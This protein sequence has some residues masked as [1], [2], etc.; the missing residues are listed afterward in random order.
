MEYILFP[1]E[2]HGF[3]KVPNR[4]RSDVEVTRWFVRVPGGTGAERQQLKVPAQ[5]GSSSMGFRSELV[6]FFSG[7][8]LRPE[9]PP[10]GRGPGSA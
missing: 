4:I 5:A 8:C 9:E 6:Y 10:W 3:R 7:F 2:G 1:D